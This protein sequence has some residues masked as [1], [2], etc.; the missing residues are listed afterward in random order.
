MISDKSK[1]NGNE[2][3][4][5]LKWGSHFCYLYNNEE[6]LL[7]LI[8][9]YFKIGLENNEF[10]MWVTS[11]NLSPEIA[12]GALREA[13]FD[14]DDYE[15]RGQIKIFS[16]ETWY[17]RNTLKFEKKLEVVLADWLNYLDL[18]LTTGYKGLRVS[19]DL[20]WIKKVDLEHFIDYE[21]QVNN[22]IGDIKMMAICTY[23]IN[24]F[25]KFEFLDIANS[26]QFVLT[27]IDG[28]YQVI[29]NSELKR[30]NRE[31]KIIKSNIQNIQKMETIGIL[32][33]GI[34]HEFKNMLNLI[35]GN[36]ELAMMRT[37]KENPIYKNL[38]EITQSIKNASKLTQKMFNFNQSQVEEKEKIDLNTNIIKL[39]EILAY[40]IKDN[41]RFET[42]LLPNLWAIYIDPGKIEQIILNLIMNAKDAMPDGGKIIIK[43]EN[44]SVDDSYINK[45]PKIKSG[46]YICLSI[47]DAGVGIEKSLL[48]RIFEPFFTT[49]GPEKGTGLG[50][51]IVNLYV[52]ESSGYIDV[53][54]E[55][56]KGTTFKI[57]LPTSNSS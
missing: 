12:I 56:N 46:N 19:G 21:I 38:E 28:K 45:N 14:F 49:K 44:V 4:N 27:S 26:H 11:D 29:E 42:N 35:K 17:A 39:V 7:K 3:I 2:I 5:E 50:L 16:A 54:S 52:S 20:R 10:C 43:T 8:V 33:S 9:P 30:I 34:A 36:A 55:I 13:I 41:I 48:K 47:E 57:M 25:N 40:F 6:D 18:A 1:N 22:I 23:P 24:K 37:K 31:Q 51:P 32:S 53:M 15:K